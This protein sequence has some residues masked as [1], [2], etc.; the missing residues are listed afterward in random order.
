MKKYLCTLFFIILLILPLMAQQTVDS[1]FDV[2]DQT[3][4]DT[5]RLRLLIEITDQLKM[6]DPDT[7]IYYAL[8]IREL[9]EELEDQ[10]GIARGL[11][12]SG[13]IYHNLGLLSLAINNLDASRILYEQLEDSFGLATVYN[14][15]GNLYQGSDEDVAL[16]YYNLS[17]KIFQD[18]GE[19]RYLPHLYLNMATSYDTKKE[20][21]KGWK[22]NFEALELLQKA[23][24]STRVIISA[25]LNIGEHY[26]ST[27]DLDNALLYYHQGL[28]L[29]KELQNNPRLVDSYILLGKY[30]NLTGDY[31]HSISYLDSAFAIA[32]AQ[33]FLPEIRDNAEL[34]ADSYKKKGDYE[35]A[36][37]Y[38]ELFLQLY[39][40]INQMQANSMLKGLE[41]VAEHN[42]EMQQKEAD[43]QK[44]K[45]FRNFTMI[46]LLLV[47]ISLFYMYRNYRIKNKAN[48]LLAEV[49]ALKTR[50]FSNIS[51]E[52]RNP[53]TLILDPIEQMLDDEQHKGPSTRTLKLM[54]RNV[55]KML[56]L[57]NQ[58]LDLS[59][60]DA[61]KLKI[62]L[63]QGNVIHHLKII[64][65]SFTSLAEKK[66]IHYTIHCPEEEF[67]TYFDA[68]KMDKIFTNLIGNALK[69]TDDGG[70]VSVRVE[71]DR[72]RVRKRKNTE[73]QEILHIEVR[74][75]GNGIPE[76]ELTK[77]FDRF[78]QVGGKDEPKKVGTG[79]G[80]SLTKELIDLLKGKITVESNVNLGTRF[81]LTI[82][83]GTSHLDAT[84][85]VVVEE[86]KKS[87]KLED[88][89]V[90]LEEKNQPSHVGDDR[91][92][93]LIVEDNEDIRTHITD[94]MAE[95]N[96]MEAADGAEGLQI[97][98]EQL[99]DLVI[100]DLMMP[101]MD[102]VELC[103]KLKTD[104]RTSHIPLIMLTAKTSVE[105]RIEGLETG[106]DDY[107]TKPFNIKELRVRVKNLIKQ[108]QKLRERFRKELILE[109][110]EIAVTS[111]DER[112]IIQTLEVIEKNM[113]DEDFSVEQ[114]GSELAMSRMQLFRKI[115]ALTDQSPSEYIRTIRLK[116]AAHLIKSNFGNLAEIT[117]EVGFN[118]P[119][120]FAKCFRELY[121]VAPSEYNKN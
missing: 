14:A 7:A 49:D 20:Y 59:K 31:D 114:L 113:S 88:E 66:K 6:S 81:N 60:L 75:T 80:L 2:L 16:D 23:D 101:K 84:D 22:Y 11:Y 96:V 68:D 98:T 9:A 86:Q 93:I 44:Q 112:F 111:V 19:D 17:L 29:S 13:V 37:H 71:T 83:L 32:T 67:I 3:I 69:Y 4:D 79:I 118:H 64:A 94:N 30:Y 18:L 72:E 97:A 109:P 108:R 47:M 50:M 105:D 57:I 92:I 95:Y 39:D 34:L 100:T 61:G 120:Y 42:I 102:G 63:S 55:N 48:T 103:E 110:R 12:F 106:A 40:S 78:Y 116:R 115:K 85:Y 74:D 107:L 45:L 73:D 21:A 8:Q 76:D 87:D 65:L 5:T 121:G 10:T 28:A 35:S 53:L 117:Y 15:F 24:D 51:H 119:S 104:E 26:E 46:A 91:Q 1:L 54:E 90:R 38:A 36:L 99:P 77:I 56:N 52:L 62:E 41:L 43:L 33:N 25:L 70:T 82:P 27:D 89:P 58:L